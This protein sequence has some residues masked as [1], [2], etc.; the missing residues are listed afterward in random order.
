MCQ[1]QPCRNGGSCQDIPGAFVCECPTGF[2][3][4][5]CDQGR[6]VILSPMDKRGGRETWVYSS[7]LLLPCPQRQ[8][9]VPAAPAST[10]AAVRTV[11]PGPTCACALRASS[12]TTAR[13][14]GSPNYPVPSHGEA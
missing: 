11:G 5:L 12:G 6:M 7:A 4:T 13:Q 10:E 3:G 2:S 9:L 8:P 1:A 14:V